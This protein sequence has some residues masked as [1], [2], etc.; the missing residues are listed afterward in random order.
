MTL[1]RRLLVPVLVVALAELLLL[2]LGTWQVRRLHWKEGILAR[3][4]AAEHAPVRPLGNDPPLYQRVTV[5]G[6]FRYDL[7]VKYG[8]EGRD[9]VKG[10]VL[11]HF[12]LVPL[13]RDN[14]PA[15]LVNRGW[16]PDAPGAPLDQPAGVV[17]VTGF[18]RPGSTANWF[19]PADNQP[20]RLFYTLDPPVIA[21]ALGIPDALP[22]SLTVLGPYQPDRFPDPARDFPRPPNNHLSYA[23]TWYS[24]AAIMLVMFVIRVR[25]RPAAGAATAYR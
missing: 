25:A 11:G 24:L 10:P 14:A 18:V 15:L 23:V 3:I 16:V 13:E 5:T 1:P 22:F 6:R 4:D 20:E 9:T 8:I 19:S 2:G 12:Q 21:A 7:A 17:T